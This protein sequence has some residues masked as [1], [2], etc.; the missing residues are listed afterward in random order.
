V[1]EDFSEAYGVRYFGSATA[2]RTPVPPPR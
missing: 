2:T 1:R